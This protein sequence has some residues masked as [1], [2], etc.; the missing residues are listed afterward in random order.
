[1]DC[2]DGMDDA[3]MDDHGM[4]SGNSS[5]M[6]DVEESMLPP[7]HYED[8]LTGGSPTYSDQGPDGMF[9]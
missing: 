6:M 9:L 2:E 4:S 1:M 8:D 5:E 7:Q 3:W